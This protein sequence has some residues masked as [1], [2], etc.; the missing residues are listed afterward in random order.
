M[1]VC[2]TS[3]QPPQGLG[4][5]ACIMAA[6]MNHEQMIG[7][8]KI[9]YASGT[10]VGQSRTR[11]TVKSMLVAHFKSV[12]CLEHAHVLRSRACRCI[13][14]QCWIL[15]VC[16]HHEQA[17]WKLTSSPLQPACSTA[18]HTYLVLQICYHSIFLNYFKFSMFS[19]FM[20]FIVLLVV[21]H[22][23]TTLVD[24]IAGQLR[25]ALTIHGIIT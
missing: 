2:L 10:V 1:I 13:M 18:S 15:P 24:N 16:H 5:A 19:F 7:A 6:T 14:I 21:G 20:M 22:S 17:N 9:P 25:L 3:L 11:F 12:S 8:T 4:K 23:G